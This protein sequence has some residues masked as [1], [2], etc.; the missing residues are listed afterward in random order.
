MLRFARG[1]ADRFRGIMGV[2]APAVIQDEDVHMYPC[3]AFR[4][5]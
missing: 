3:V 4:R 1:I 5:P 2:A